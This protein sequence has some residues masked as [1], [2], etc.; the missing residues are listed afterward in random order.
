MKGIVM[1]KVDY[2][3]HGTG[4]YILDAL[5]TM[6]SIITSGAIK[7]R[8]NLGKTDEPTSWNGIDYVSVCAYDGDLDIIDSS[9]GGWIQ[10]CPCFILSNDIDAIKCEY[11][12]D[13]TDVGGYS[14]YKDEWHVKGDIPIDKVIGIA[15]PDIVFTDEEKELVEDIISAA[16]EFGW[17]IFSSTDALADDV[18]ERF[19]GKKK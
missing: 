1:E 18:R 15:L 14:Q 9:F 5:N 7:C 12:R 10:Y 2:F 16:N 3:Y 8:R 17:E 4:E 11:T 19:K 6:K 13:F